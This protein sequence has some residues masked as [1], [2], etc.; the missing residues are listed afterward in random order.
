MGGGRPSKAKRGKHRWIG[1]SV[2]ESLDERESL[3]AFLE[4]ALELSRAWR[5][6]DLQVTDDGLRAI[7]RVRLEDYPS[8]LE[9]FSE[10]KVVSLTASGKIRLVRERLG[11]Q[12]PA[13]RRH[14]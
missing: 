10:G 3:N 5:L 1:L 13:R 7:I 12:R 11:L 2:D 4:S 14:R 8:A 9:A 6:Y